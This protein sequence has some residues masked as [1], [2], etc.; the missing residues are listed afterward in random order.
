M[1]DLGKHG[2]RLAWTAA[3]GLW[4]FSVRA[5]S[6]LN[7]MGQA[8][9]LAW[10]TANVV[11]LEALFK[12]TQVV[13]DLVNQLLSPEDRDEEAAEKV[14]EFALVDLNNDGN[15][16][17]VCTVDATGR[18]FFTSVVVLSQSKG[19][20]IQAHVSTN[21][22][23]LINLPSHLVDLNHDGIK[24]ILVPRLLGP[25]AGADP[26]AAFTDVYTL[27]NGRLVQSD[28]QF[29]EYYVHSKLPELK[30]QLARLRLER[31]ARA[32]K[33]IA[34]AQTEIE[35]INRFLVE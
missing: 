7:I 30:A 11:R 29:R 2:M 19:E 21:G 8:N 16:E 10:T 28:K 6:D 22:Y 34:A 5:D 25:Y 12:N 1:G 9:A 24:E 15:L 18:D 33:S 13:S 26:V 3:L 20:T 14:G 31:T 23:N 32:Y 27:L 17:L 35:A 4:S